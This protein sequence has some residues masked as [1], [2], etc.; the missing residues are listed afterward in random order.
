MDGERGGTR[1]PHLA[2]PVD[3]A[4]AIVGVLAEA[5]ID[6]V[7]GLPGGYTGGLFSALHAHDRIRV[8]QVREESIGS[9]MA[10]A[11]GRLTGRPVVVMGQGEWIA[12]NAGQGFLEAL[13]G[14]APIVVLTEM[15][16]G[17]ALSHH[18]PYQGGTGDYGSWDA[19]GALQGMTKRVMVSHE[20][21]QAVQHTQLAIK[22]ATTG[23]PGPVAV[24]FHGDALRGT[25][26]PDSHPRPHPTA[27]YLPAPVGPDPA[28]VEGAAEAIARAER[29]VVLAGNGVR[30][31]QACAALAAFARAA[32]LP[33]ATTAGGK[34]VFD[35]TDPRCAGVIG[36]F[37]NA[38]A[39]AVVGDADL[40]VA[41]GTRLAPIDTGDENPAL[42]DP[43]RQ[44]FVHVDVEPLN[45]G[46]TYP[47]DHPVVADAGLALAAL[48]ERVPALRTAP[49]APGRT[50]AAAASGTARAPE[51]AAARVAGARERHDLPLGHEGEADEMPMPPQRIVAM[52]RERLPAGA[53]VTGDAGENRLFMLQWWRQR[54]PG[55]YLQPA[56]GGGMG[57]AVPA[58]LGARL[59]RPDA[60]VVA[61]VGDGGFAMSIHGLMVAVQERLPIAVVVFNNG[62]LGWVLHGMGDRAVAAGFDDFDHAA[63]ARSLG[64]DGVRVTT[65]GELATALDRVG[66][67]PVPLVIDV[68]TSLKTSFK[69][70]VQ[71]LAGSR[72]KA[73]D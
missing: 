59:A 11:Y 68:P 61:V 2:G 42:L 66:D 60:P 24:I 15:S 21:A 13:L 38:P 7:L 1:A 58:A 27:G 26:G 17:G 52:L 56:A 35:E 43:H 12:G 9:A 20:P 45:V 5:G 48:A 16:D 54:L 39:N 19:R 6:H 62:A 25:V 51:A 29:P 37:G 71:P 18:A 72:W 22:H 55:A 63:I 30:V 44:T 14:S 65:P 31:G 34:G 8:V 28:A 10:D 64:C 47:V 40:V 70:V 49:T 36:T 33:V 50:G 57:Y 23:D 67:S 32:D 3:V 4:D 73:G 69:D 53:I 46:W 41:V